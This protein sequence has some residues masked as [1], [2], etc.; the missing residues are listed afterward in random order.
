MESIKRTQLGYTIA[1]AEKGV[2][3]HLRI[4]VP[5][6][7]PVSRFEMLYPDIYKDIIKAAPSSEDELRDFWVLESDIFS[8][9][10]A[11][12]TARKIRQILEPS[13][14]I[15][16]E[17]LS[18]NLLRGIVDINRKTYC[19]VWNTFEKE[20]FG[21][22]YERILAIHTQ[23]LKEMK[24]IL[25]KTHICREVHTMSPRRPSTIVTVTPETVNERIEAWRNLVGEDL[26]I[27][28]ISKLEGTDELNVGDIPAIINQK[29]KLELFGYKV[30]LSARYHAGKDYYSPVW[31]KTVD[32][33]VATDFPK[34]YGS[35]E[36]PGEK[37]FILWQ[38]TQD[39]Q[40]LESLAVPY[41]LSIIDDILNSKKTHPEWF[42]C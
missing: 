17:I 1:E 30:G 32:S 19:A 20:S 34:N 41:A 39:L 36:Q 3:P 11:L 18:V 9:E 38:L 25:Q 7:A 33:Y 15:R 22:L 16:I 27:D 26:S 6:G 40:R 31:A 24:R 28:I 10:L 29:K 8:E 23:T 4:Y 5:H 42:H 35:K 21:D 14:D 2:E 37:D 12:F 13:F